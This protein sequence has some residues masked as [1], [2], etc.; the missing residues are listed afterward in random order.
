MNYDCVFGNRIKCSDAE[1]KHSLIL[2]KEILEQ[3][4]LARSAGFMVLGQN[5]DSLSNPFLRDSI[6]LVG[7]GWDYDAVERILNIRIA[8]R[9]AEGILLLEMAM[10][11]EGILSIMRGEPSGI[12]E[13]ILF[14]FLGTE[15]YE[16]HRKLQTADHER[17]VKKLS[18]AKESANTEAGE[19]I[20]EAG[21]NEISFLL[22]AFDWE[23]LTYILKDESDGVRYRIFSNLGN[24]AGKL[25][26]ERLQS[27]REPEKKVKMKAVAKFNS[28]AERIKNGTAVLPAITI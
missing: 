3:S 16:T 8:V 4:K 9:N 24:E 17:F 27:C 7:K 23:S 21:D 2:I 13:E 22:K 18:S 19:W 15:F 1:K 11:K 12:T 5:A 25:F 20:L 14:S 10:I 6:K 28:L 26:R